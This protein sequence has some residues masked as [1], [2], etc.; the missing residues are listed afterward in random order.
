MSKLTKQ[1]HILEANPVLI[2]ELSDFKKLTSRLF[3]TA[4]QNI[5]SSLKIEKQKILNAQK[6]IN[7]FLQKTKSND[8][9][10]KG[11]WSKFESRFQFKKFD[12]KIE[13]EYSAKIGAAV[14]IFA[15]YIPG[16]STRI[17]DPE[18]SALVRE[19]LKLII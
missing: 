9:L 14:P 13:N 12:L 3:V 19:K 2:P 4:F 1:I 15:K 10:I 11:I 5:I 18:N 17:T 6:E 8:E 16:T 7:D